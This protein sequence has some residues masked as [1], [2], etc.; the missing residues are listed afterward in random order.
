MLILLAT[1]TWRLQRAERVAAR[2]AEDGF[3]RENT[4]SLA[5]LLVGFLAAMAVVVEA[6]RRGEHEGVKRYRRAFGRNCLQ[7]LCSYSKA[8]ALRDWLP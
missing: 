1:P 7:Q 4:S 6:W 3:G 5:E 8:G 2:M